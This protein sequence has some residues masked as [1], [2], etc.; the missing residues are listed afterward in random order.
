MAGVTN[1]I[2]AYPYGVNQNDLVGYGVAA[3]QQLYEGCVALM[4]GG[5]GGIT[6]GYLKNAATSYAS[7]IVVGMIDTPAGGTYVAT[8][9][10]I[11]GGATDGAVWANV[12]TGSFMFQSGSGS[13]LLS[14]ATNGKTVYYGGE[15]ASG[16][17]ACAT[18][19]GGTRPSLGTQLPQDPGFANNY[20]P[21]SNYW[22][23]KLNVVGGP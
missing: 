4:S 19:S 18:S 17:I 5:S 21:G 10:G 8:G 7:D 16:P 20:I 1:D 9:P 12:R 22:P 6:Q 15:N 14:A 3:T 23:V 2:T 13:D 11:L